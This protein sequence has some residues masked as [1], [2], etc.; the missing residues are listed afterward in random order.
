VRELPGERREDVLALFVEA[1]RP[2]HALVRDALPQDV[3]DPVRAL[4]GL[5]HLPAAERGG[6]LGGESRLGQA[7]RLAVDVRHRAEREPFRVRDPGRHVP[8]AVARAAGEQV[9]D[10]GAQ[11]VRDR[12]LQRQVPE[13]LERRRRR[14]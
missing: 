6:V 8:V 5:L 12:D 13:E 11:V 10:L 1:S 9:R 4:L 14:R 3:D 7:H 2:F